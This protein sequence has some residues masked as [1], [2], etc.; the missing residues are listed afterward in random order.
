VE[1]TTRTTG[2]GSCASTILAVILILVPVVG[3]IACTVFIL[4]DDLTV[5]EK[6]L[7]LVA[8]WVLTPFVGIL[9]Y[10]LLG[11]KRNRLLRA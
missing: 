1:P 4:T 10:L 7:W 5:A 9:L 2:G 6:I 11:Q 3:H 8:V